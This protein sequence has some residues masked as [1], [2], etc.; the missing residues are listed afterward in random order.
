MV[1]RVFIGGLIA[2]SVAPG[3]SD[4]DHDR[5]DRQLVYTVKGLTCPA[6]SRLGCGHLLAP[7][8]AAL[9]KLEGVEQSFANRTGTMIRVTIAASAERG[10]V[11]GAVS[12]YLAE[13]KR[14]P[15]QLAGDE[16]KHALDKEEWRGTRRIAELTAIEFR[17]LA[18]GQVR[19]FA[20]AEKLD[21]KLAEKLVAL[22]GEEFDRTAGQAIEEIKPASYNK[23]WMVRSMRFI[24]SFTER[25]EDLLTVE[26]Q[27]RLMERFMQ[28][29]PAD[30]P[31][32]S[33]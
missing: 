33:K 15:V 13:K 24:V 17:T 29:C 4:S 11:A 9:D 23:A 25:A 2:L 32:N 28:C 14:A 16:L 6:V 3:S 26:Q 10:K 5:P 7:E 30:E 31:P 12:K 1:P 8:L 21:A 19:K 18:L 27:A 20:E 22:A